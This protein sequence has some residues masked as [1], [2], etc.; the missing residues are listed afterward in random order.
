VNVMIL[1][2]GRGTRLGALSLATP[3]ILV[4]IEGRPLLGRQLDYLA[5]QGAGRVV[6]NAFHLA[7]QVDAFVESYAG[8]L[9]VRVS[10]EPSLLGTAGGVRYALDLLGDGPFVVL[11][12]DVLTTEPLAPLLDSHRA[13]G[14]AVTLGVYESHDVADKGIVMVDSDGFVERFS[15]KD[16][17][18]VGPALINGGIYVVDPNVLTHWPN[19]AELDF[20]YDVFPQI[21]IWGLTIGSYRLTRPL[22]DIGS[23]AMLEEGRRYFVARTNM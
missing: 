19:G 21:T 18:A 10:R 2:A 5:E 22:Y 3:K 6:V 15:E 20:G 7:D 4:D 14:A 12:G 17:E 23:P 1:G 16:P 9:D 11:Y 13:S 8:S